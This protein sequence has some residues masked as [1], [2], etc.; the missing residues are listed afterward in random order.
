MHALTQTLIHRRNTQ[1]V[2]EEERMKVVE[3]LTPENWLRIRSAGMMWCN[4]DAILQLSP[5][6]FLLKEASPLNS[7]LDQ[8]R[9]IIA[10]ILKNTF[11]WIVNLVL[12]CSQSATDIDIL[13]TAT[14]L[15]NCPHCP[16]PSHPKILQW[17]NNTKET[18]LV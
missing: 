2:V 14:N 6:D 15:A 5:N 11:F 18:M 3:I 7:T 10:V 17:T 13:A 16:P 12:L 1:S 4:D 9:Y 8:L